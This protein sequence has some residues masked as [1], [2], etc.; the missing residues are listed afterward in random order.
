MLVTELGFITTLLIGVTLGIV[1]FIILTFWIQLFNKDF[2]FESKFF[3]P[4]FWIHL[5]VWI[6]GTCVIPYDLVNDSFALWGWPFMIYIFGSLL[7]MGIVKLVKINQAE[8][9]QPRT[10]YTKS[11]NES[12]F[13]SLFSDDNKNLNNEA[14]SNQPS[15]KAHAEELLR[16]LMDDT[17]DNRISSNPKASETKYKYICLSDA[18]DVPERKSGGIYSEDIILQK[19]ESTIKTSHIST[20]TK[21]N[22]PETALK[23]REYISVIKTHE[24]WIDPTED[25]KDIIFSLIYENDIHRKT[26]L[27]LDG[28]DN[29]NKLFETIKSTPDYKTGSTNLNAIVH[30]RIYLDCVLALDSD[31]DTVNEFYITYK[32]T[33]V[34]NNSVH[35]Y[36]NLMIK[37]SDLLDRIIVYL[38]ENL[39]KVSLDHYPIAERKMRKYLNE[40]VDD[41]TDWNKI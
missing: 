22:D 16:S 20:S 10:T 34:M 13:E 39:D 27:L 18:N 30:F 19:P 33:G 23:A 5:I 32:L 37:I 21:T 3:W 29:L 2:D 40:Y 17:N 35:K 28:L 4:L 38:F 8:K 31:G 11:K 15:Q 14:K 12:S 7:I 1:G 6:I 36:I 41:N 9:K 26:D 24:G 25:F